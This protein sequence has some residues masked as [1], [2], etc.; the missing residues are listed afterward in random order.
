MPLKR[1]PEG[2]DLCEW[3]DDWVQTEKDL[4]EAKCFEW[5]LILKDFQEIQHQVDHG[6]ASTFE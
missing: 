5:G 4:K 3:I 6:Y 1:F 2:R